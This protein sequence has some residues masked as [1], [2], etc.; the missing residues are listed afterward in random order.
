MTKQA[1][2]IFAKN[3]E[4]GKV[5]TRLAATIG[6][7]AALSVYKQLLEHTAIVTRNIPVDKFVFYSNHV[8]E[9]DVW[10]N[11][12]YSKRVQK[13]NDLGEKMKNAFAEIFHLGY[14]NVVLI[15]TDCPKITG[16][17][18]G[19]A[20]DKLVEVDAVIGPALDGGYY[21]IGLKSNCSSIFENISWS[22]S[23]VLQETITKCKSARLLFIL[24]QTLQDIDEENDLL[25]LNLHWL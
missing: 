12:H 16:A 18:I 17:I 20:F 3:L 1:L 24:L 10:D 15:G 22:T 7:D 5:K 2:L 21:L 19:E 23:S 4:V 6:K 9:K 11:E 14:S 25:N 8:V 13:G